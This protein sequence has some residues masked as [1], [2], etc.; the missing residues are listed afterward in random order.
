M[1]Q[2]AILLAVSPDSGTVP[3]RAIQTI[4]ATL[5]RGH[6]VFCFLYEDGVHFAQRLRDVPKGE[7]DPSGELAR[8]ASNPNCDVV[9]CITAAER[10]GVLSDHLT[11]N[12]RIGGLGE[13]TAKLT[14]ADRVVQFR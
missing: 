12:I 14:T 10:R 2:F 9:T 6:A 4:E 1:K 11:E 13:W 3:I 5:S 7:T 8:L